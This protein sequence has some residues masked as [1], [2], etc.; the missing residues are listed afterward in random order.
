MRIGRGNRSTLRKPAL[1]PFWSSQIPHNLTWERTQ[2]TTV[3]FSW[4]DCPTQWRS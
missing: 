3:L 1:T 2:D 4:Y